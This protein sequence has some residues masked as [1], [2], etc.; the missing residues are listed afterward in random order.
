MPFLGL[1]AAS[2]VKVQ[3][4]GL[5]QD[6]VLLRYGREVK[7]FPPKRAGIEYSKSCERTRKGPEYLGGARGRQPRSALRGARS[8][9]RAE[10]RL[11]R[12]TRRSHRRGALEVARSPGVTAA[13]RCPEGKKEARIGRGFRLR[14]PER[15][16]VRSRRSRAQVI[17][18]VRSDRL[19]VRGTPFRVHHRREP[20]YALTHRSVSR[21]SS[22]FRPMPM[23]PPCCDSACRRR[24]TGTAARE[25]CSCERSSDDVRLQGRRAGCRQRGD[26][27][28]SGHRRAGALASGRTWRPRSAALPNQQAGRRPCTPVRC[29]VESTALPGNGIFVVLGQIPVRLDR[30]RVCAPRDAAAVSSSVAPRAIRAPVY[31]DNRSEPANLVW[32]L[33]PRPRAPVFVARESSFM[34]P[35]VERGGPHVTTACVTLSD[36][37]VAPSTAGAILSLGARPLCP[38]YERTSRWRLARLRRDRRIRGRRRMTSARA[39]TACVSS[40]PSPV[41]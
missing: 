17:E 3:Y 41:R 32:R 2:S 36:V 15:A 40:A 33:A 9:N 34:L 31:R 21:S 5:V 19:F 39:L 38:R 8:E 27:P 26:S 24:R 30:I 28:P 18:Q 1:P 23:Q 10:H 6:T 16:S 37:F 4:A 7:G 12:E 22:I 29:Q 35:A 13:R 25:R 11:A 14:P 20:W